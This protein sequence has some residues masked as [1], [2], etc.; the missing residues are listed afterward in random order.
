MERICSIIKSEAQKSSHLLYASDHRIKGWLIAMASIIKAYK[1]RILNPS[2]AVQD[3]L[4]Q[5]LFLCRDLYNAALSERKQAYSLNKISIN[6]QHQQNQLPEI[7]R[8]NPE[9]KEAY[10]QVL[11]NVLKRVDFA[12][13]GFF[14]RIKRKEKA[15]YPRFRGA[16]R[17]D[18]FTYPQ[19]GFSLTG[20]KLTLSKIGTVKLRLSRK[21]QG[22]L[23]TL[24]IKNECG[25]WFAV[26]TVETS[27]EPLPET[28][29]VVGIDAGISSFL[30]LSDGT[31]VENPRFY[32]TLQKQLRVAQRNVSRKK[33]GGKNRKKAV[34]KLRKIHQ[35]IR[36]CRLDF[37]H[38]P[39]RILVTNFDFIA[40]EDL[41]VKNML[42][43]HHL[44]KAIADVSWS[45]FYS[46]LESKAEW[47]DRKFVKVNPKNTSQICSR[48]GELVKKGL[49]V[50]V[51]HCHN[52]NLKICRDTNAAINIL[53]SGLDRLALNLPLGVFA[54]ES[55]LF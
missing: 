4:E 50:R 13:Q 26:F 5:T 49:S 23:K 25:K 20:N 55:P 2:K 19:S 21:V 11:Q 34:L 32:Q 8:T 35:K 37:H 40:I 48:C 41:R 39:A 7:K 42:K 46:I 16:N 18:S 29:K 22:K 52:C 27:I 53:R 15:G 31:E 44:A 6:Y 33:K 14:Q 1:F 10:S 36:N 30:T 43:E 47:A 51:H 45:S 24:T 54:K 17:Y 9:Y 28:N 12:F 38:K 3:R